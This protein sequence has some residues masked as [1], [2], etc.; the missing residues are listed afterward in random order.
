MVRALDDVSLEIRR[1]EFFTLLGPSG[2]GKTTLLRLLAGFE[3]PEAGTL[4]LDGRPILEEPPNRRPVNMV[5]QSYALFPH[6]SVAQNVAFGLEQLGAARRA[7]DER[8][9]AMLRLVRLEDM[10]DRKPSQ[11]SGGQ[12]QR[13]ALARALAPDPKLLLLDEPL[14]ALDRKLRHGMQLELKRM[15]RETGVTFL[16]VTHDQEEALSM[17][18][19]IAVMDSGR[20]VQLGTPHSFYEQP[21]TAFVAEFMGANVI[22]G[23]LVGRPEQILAIRPERVLLAADEDGIAAHVE[24]VTYFGMTFSIIVALADGQR[25]NVIATDAPHVGARVWCRFP[26][27]ALWPLEA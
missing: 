5:F 15:Q 11:L 22:P 4:L 9:N 24:A 7:I 14:S 17:S 25:R 23:A 18:D 26:A 3:R 16:L 19:R 2:C 6:M 8:V 10:A 13:I 27:D 20:I 21:R 1:N 12:Q